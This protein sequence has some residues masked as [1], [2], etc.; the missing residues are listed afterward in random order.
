MTRSYNSR[1]QRRL[2]RNHLAWLG[3]ETCLEVLLVGGGTVSLESSRE[4]F[5]GS[6][7]SLFAHHFGNAN[8]IQC[9]KYNA[10]CSQS[11]CY[12][13]GLWALG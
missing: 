7:A 3:S 8:S 12:V 10:R 2:L 6:G 1:A 13:S 4:R 5:C 11:R 9:I